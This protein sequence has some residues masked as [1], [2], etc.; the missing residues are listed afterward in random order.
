ME[1]GGRRRWSGERRWRKGKVDREVG[2][3]DG[4]RKGRR[5]VECKEDKGME[6]REKYNN[7]QI[8]EAATV[9]DD[10]LVACANIMY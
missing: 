7:T 5:R 1:G 6:D 4:G 2:W 8:D 9:F 10:G 3:R